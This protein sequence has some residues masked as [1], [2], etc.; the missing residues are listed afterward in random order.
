MLFGDEAPV[1][2]AGE[3]AHRI[4]RRGIV[5]V[6]EGRQVFANM[7]VAEN[8]RLGAYHV[9]GPEAARRSRRWRRVS[10]GSPSACASRRATSRAASSRCWRW[11]AR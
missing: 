5:Q 9:P 4:A 2:I 10:R 1:D 7:T 3:A 8:L 6:P 11:A